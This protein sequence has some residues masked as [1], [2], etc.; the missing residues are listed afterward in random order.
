MQEDNRGSQRQ[1]SGP[2]AWKS[3]DRLRVVSYLIVG[4][5]FLA[6]SFIEGAQLFPMV[7]EFHNGNAKP[8]RIGNS[9]EVD[10]DK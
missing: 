7:L 8:T 10:F 6:I 5:F 9:I 1:L 3:V 4:E 2:N